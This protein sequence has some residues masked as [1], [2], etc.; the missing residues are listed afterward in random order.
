MKEVMTSVDIATIIPELAEKIFGKR[1]DNVYHIPPETFIIRLRP[2]DLRLLIDVERRI[3]LTRY[4]Y[5]TPQKPSNLCMALRKH[6]VGG[7]VE[8][9][10][11]Y[12]FERIIEVKVSTRA[13]T[14][15]LVAE[16]FRR[17]NLI[18]VGPDRK[19][20]LS[21]RYARMRDRE[22]IRGMEYHPAPLSGLNP[23][24]ADL[25]KL[26]SLPEAGSKSILKTITSILSI[27]P[28][29]S[30]EVLIRAGVEAETEARNV[31]EHEVTSLIE[32]LKDI[33][34][35]IV[36]RDLEPRIVLDDQNKPL[37][38]T[39][40]PLKIYECKPF[41]NFT[42]FNEASDEYFSTITTN[43]EVEKAKSKMLEEE[44]R[45]LRILHEQNLQ[46]RMLEETAV[47]DRRRGDLIYSNLHWIRGFIDEILEM[48]IKGL[49]IQEINDKLTNRASSLNIPVK[50]RLD[51]EYV[52][53]EIE[54]LKFKI[55]RGETPQQAAERYYESAKKSSEKL[56]RLQESMK[57]VEAKITNLSSTIEV[58][59]AKIDIPRLRREK[60]WYEKF[61]WFKSSDNILVLS[62][63][64]AST[65]EL[66]IRRYLEN[67][68][69]VLHAEIHGAPFTIIKAG[70]NLPP[71]STLIEAAQ[72][73][74]SRSKAWSL[75]LTA[76]D[77][78]WVKPDQVTAKAPSGEYLGRG[79]FMITGKRNYIR[80]VELRMA[81]GIQRSDGEVYF[82]AGPP[83]AIKRHAEAYVELVPGETSAG[84]LARKIIEFL[85][86]TD[87]R[88]LSDRTLRVLVEDVARL[89]P[90]GR[91]NILSKGRIVP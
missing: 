5:P 84:R 33:V 87:I 3:H 46:K 20:I 11:Q 71:E 19:I 88:G 62:G 82:I 27:G 30:K 49:K 57:L 70:G 74:A 36:Q 76:I 42:S 75:G 68:D 18:L 41:K 39:P 35:R 13:G 80:G 26:R 51:E 64:D 8:S 15:L 78:Y 25:Q 54:G 69:I 23:L 45:L 73:T 58:E 2:G 65:N 22:I 67:G 10:Q 29:Y 52:N 59:K 4:D 83:S 60:A 53:F 14:L 47:E 89:I 72:A 24:K 40:F 43:L 17:G 50:P 34:R 31:G 1:V 9:I 77:V 37:D 61:N 79:Q 81:I 16:L 6:L 66:L 85:R 86:P 38:V 55:G 90:A 48:K 12:E 56:K 91:G 21:L 7:T 44:S 28:L 32:S 63:R